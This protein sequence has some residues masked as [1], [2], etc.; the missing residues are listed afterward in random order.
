ML[1]TEDG[2]HLHF[3]V[4]AIEEPTKEIMRILGGDPTAPDVEHGEFYGGE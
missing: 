4:F 2:E 3:S 1:K